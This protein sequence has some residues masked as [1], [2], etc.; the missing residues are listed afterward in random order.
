ME[1]SCLRTRKTLE[2]IPTKNEFWEVINKVKLTP[3]QME[4]L[5]L[6]FIDDLLVYE[7]G[8]KMGISRK[9]VERDLRDCYRKIKRI[10]DRLPKFIRHNAFLGNEECKYCHITNFTVIDFETATAFPDS[11]CQIGIAIVEN[12]KIVKTLSYYIKPPTI[13]FTN[14]KIH[15]IDYSKVKNAPNFGELWPTIKEYIQGKII[16][17]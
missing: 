3:R 17:A 7:I 13:E 10:L 1:P 4:I 15:G 12:N 2:D 16:A 11:V 5:E 6:R 14:T 9:T 8:E